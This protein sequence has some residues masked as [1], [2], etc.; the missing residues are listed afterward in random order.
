MLKNDAYMLW[1]VKCFKAEYAKMTLLYK[2]FGSAAAVYNAPQSDIRGLKGI[3]AADLKEMFSGEKDAKL[4]EY[5]RLLEKKHIDFV[6]IESENY[7]ALLRHIAD[8]PFG[9]FSKGKLIDEPDT[10]KVA[11]IGS[12]DCTDYGRNA[13][14]RL[15]RDIAERGA[16]VVSGLARGIDGTAHRG[17][18]DGNGYTIAVLGTAIDKCYPK[19]NTELFDE[20]EKS[21]C[22]VSEYPPDNVY[23]TMNFPRR[24][25][26]IS[27]LS[28]GVVVIEA[29]LK[30]GTG[31]TVE[32][33]IEQGREIFAVPGN[34]YSE[35]SEGTN[36]LIKDGAVMVTGYEDI[37]ADFFL[38]GHN[39]NIY[40]KK[41]SS[42]SPKENTGDIHKTAYGYDNIYDS[43]DS[44]NNKADTDNTDSAADNT[45]KEKSS[46]SKKA[47]GLVLSA[48]GHG[49]GTAAKIDTEINREVLNE[50]DVFRVYGCFGSTAV[51]PDEIVEAS[52]LPVQ[53]V[54]YALTVLEVSGMIRAVPGGKFELR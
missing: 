15:S 18:L 49:N 31:I 4:G 48:D 47:A 12:R 19:D 44:E 22:I 1:F 38:K 37:F 30:S 46:K 17:A 51:Y 3:G 34:I 54:L 52:G 9:L 7:P 27:G 40:D 32:Q 26:I 35:V 20:I 16:V 8:P 39:I 42:D 10:L 28:H 23:N 33:A 50:P 29:A 53:T 6:S 45:I 41:R 11:V 5:I 14:Y 25:R 21:G 2:R 36:A 13:A 24:N 43:K